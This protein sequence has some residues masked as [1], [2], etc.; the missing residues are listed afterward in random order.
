MKMTRMVVVLLLPLFWFTSVSWAEEQFDSSAATI[1]PFCFDSAEECQIR[2]A[3]KATKAA[4]EDAIRQRCVD[5]PAWC[6]NWRA[7]RMKQREEQKALKEQCKAN[8]K[9][10]KELR[11]QFKQK[12]KQE[13][14]EARQKQK[15]TRL[16]LRKAQKK[17]CT[18]NPIACEQWK[19]DKMEAQK[20]CQELHRQLEEK[21]PERP[22]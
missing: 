21:Y 17:W 13:Q 18:D 6:E 16:A 11:R 20:K 1:D 19:V 14:K 10:C 22:H 2:E 12:K 8:P 9:Q 3:K 7:E 15:E 5:D 4:K